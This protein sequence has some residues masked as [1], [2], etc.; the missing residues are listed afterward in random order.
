MRGAHGNRLLSAPASCLESTP[1]RA[2][3][4]GHGLVSTSPDYLRFA[5]MLLNGGE[6]DGVRLLGRKTVELMT[7]NHLPP[8]LLTIEVGGFE[9]P[10]YGYGLGFGVLMDPVQTGIL[11]SAGS[12]DWGGAAS[13]EFWIDPT[14]QLIGI[15]MAQFQPSGIHPAGQAFRAAA[16]QAIVD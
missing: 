8:H 12:F 11:G 7:V 3:R 4:G 5:Q 1:H 14:E 6:L 2:F 16:Y 15:Q 13:T 10:G 9:N